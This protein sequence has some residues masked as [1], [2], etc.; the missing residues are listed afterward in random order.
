MLR[1]GYLRVNESARCIFIV[2]LAVVIS[3]AQTPSSTPPSAPLPKVHRWFDLEALSI[4]T[5][6][7]FIDTSDG[8]TIANQQQWQLLGRGRFKF[9]QKGKYSVVAAI[10]SGTSFASGWENTGLGT[11]TVQSNLFLKQLYFDAKPIKPVEVQ[12]GGIAIA[13]GENTEITGY[14]NDN[15][16]TGERLVLR[17]PKK[18]YFDEVSFTNGYVGDL[19][20]PSVFRRFKHLNRSN[21]HQFLVRKQV[22][23]NIGFSADYTFESGADTLRQAVKVKIPK[24]RIVD[25]LLYENY[26]RIDPQPG[27]GF[28]ITA[29]KKLNAKLNLAGGFAKVSHT[30]LN[31]DRFPR[32]ERIFITG[33]FKVTRELTLSSAI[34]RAVGPLST[35]STHRTRL[36]IIASY[37]IL[38]ALRHY[39]VF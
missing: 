5:R 15:Y 21:Y 25:S 9:D 20:R 2:T 22:T 16:L 27:Y 19:N 10:Q 3:N 34:I 14:D 30:T 24:A 28:A 26:E 17:L 18:I 38:E 23:K 33:A 6:Y 8:A 12:F 32:G 11:G 36:E 1:S 35:P 7:R 4:A 39:R 31:G 13:N 29:E 37:N